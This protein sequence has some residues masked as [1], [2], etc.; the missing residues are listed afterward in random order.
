MSLLS[1]K[2]FPPNDVEGDSGVIEEQ[3]ITDFII[4]YSASKIL[5]DLGYG[6]PSRE[7]Y[8]IMKV[9]GG[10]LVMRLATGHYKS[11]LATVLSRKMSETNRLIRDEDLYNILT[12]AASLKELKNVGSMRTVESLSKALYNRFVKLICNN[13]RGLEEFVN[14]ED[15][16]EVLQ[17]LAT[18]I[19]VFIGGFHGV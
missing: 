14:P 9:L 7:L 18:G 15:P 19:A 13:S 1:L 3:L 2:E 16:D 6:S 17:M 8:N 11:G 4:T 10:E 12:L 5:E